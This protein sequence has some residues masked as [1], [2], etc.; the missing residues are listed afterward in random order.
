METREIYTGD[1]PT[2]LLKL[3]KAL[4]FALTDEASE[5]PASTTALE[6]SASTQIRTQIDELKVEA[7]EK[8]HLIEVKALGR[9]AWRDLREKHPP[10]RTGDPS[11]TEAEIEADQS[12]GVNLVTIEEDLLHAA[13][14]FPEF[15]SRAAFDEWLA[16][17]PVTPGEWTSAVTA[18]WGLTHGRP[19]DP[20]V[21][22]A[23][24]TPSTD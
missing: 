1:Y 15:A 10:R 9:N 2:R 6:G 13:L 4:E 5:A 21:I 7:R 12:Q 19:F 17:D 18:A 14:V 16:G 20:A 24:P 3:A 23:S 8:G 11:A 22:P